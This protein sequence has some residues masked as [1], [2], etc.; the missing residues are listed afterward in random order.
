[1]ITILLTPTFLA[2]RPKVARC[3]LVA[4][5]AFFSIERG[6]LMSV[7]FFELEA[8]EGTHLAEQSGSAGGTFR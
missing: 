7:K 6:H 5:R 8:A 1:M 2:T 3:W 4:P